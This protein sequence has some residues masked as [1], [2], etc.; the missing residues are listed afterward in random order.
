MHTRGRGEEQ[1]FSEEVHTQQDDLP[2]G[3]EPEN[4]NCKDEIKRDEAGREILIIVGKC[5]IS[6]TTPRSLLPDRQGAKFTWRDSWTEEQVYKIWKAYFSRRMTAHMS[7][8]EKNVKSRTTPPPRSM[9]QKIWEG[10]WN[11]WET[12]KYKSPQIRYRQNQ[13]SARNG[14]GWS[15]VYRVQFLFL[16]MQIGCSKKMKMGSKKEEGET[17]TIEKKKN[18][19]ETFST[20]EKK[21]NEGPSSTMEKKER[22]NEE[23]T[24][25]NI[26]VFYSISHKTEIMHLIG[27][28]NNSM[29]LV[30]KA[31][32]RPIAK[33][34]APGANSGTQHVSVKCVHRDCQPQVIRNLTRD[35]KRNRLISL[36]AN[37]IESF[38]YKGY[39]SVAFPLME[40]SLRS[41]MHA[42]F[43]E[44][45]PE[46]CIVV[47]LKETLKSLCFIH[48]KGDVHLQI[49][50]GNIFF[51]GNEI[52]LAC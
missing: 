7:K 36:H 32:R 17:S 29:V 4:S 47:D 23:N 35:V 44:G 13:L 38:D 24:M 46:D 10:L 18:D 22:S 52:K 33:K 1:N 16:I 42:R 34:D 3:S 37:I 41:L 15:R 21:K 31:N 19:S 5:F 27:K 8:P 14:L 26:C 9:R 48:S 12:P 40:Q 51:D 11:I 30:Y 2:P 45:F 39:H 20:I 43:S 28:Y 49:N 50:M 25:P 6:T